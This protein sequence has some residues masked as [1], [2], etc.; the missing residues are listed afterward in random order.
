MFELRAKITKS[1]TNSPAAQRKIQIAQIKLAR[2][3]R[4]IGPAEHTF[5]L[6]DVNEQIIDESSMFKSYDY[7]TLDAMVAPGKCGVR[8]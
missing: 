2:R 3:D 6:L 5:V 7:V 8:S 1:D 4:F